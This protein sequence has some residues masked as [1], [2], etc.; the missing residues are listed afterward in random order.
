MFTFLAVQSVTNIIEKHNC[1]SPATVSDLGL[2]F[3]HPRSSNLDIL[4]QNA[5]Q[6]N[7]AK[8]NRESY[9]KEQVSCRYTT[10]L[11]RDSA[12]GVLLVNFLLKNF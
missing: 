6:K 1:P 12:T 5:V 4:S 11:K 8:F 2:I 10:L 7:F 9:R 3:C